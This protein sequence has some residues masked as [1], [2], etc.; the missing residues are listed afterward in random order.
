[1]DKESPRLL[2]VEVE[3]RKVIYRCILSPDIAWM[4]YVFGTFSPA[5]VGRPKWIWQTIFE[6]DIPQ[7]VKDAVAKIVKGRNNAK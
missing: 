3:H 6:S 5:D 7:Q 4:K 1:M 2:A